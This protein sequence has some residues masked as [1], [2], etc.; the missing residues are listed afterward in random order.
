VSLLQ[1]GRTHKHLTT[2]LNSSHFD[3][4][5][6]RPRLAL[7]IEHFLAVNNVKMI[8]RHVGKMP[9]AKRF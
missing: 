8:T 9:G 3:L 4:V 7:A 6:E 2:M 1:N 5:P